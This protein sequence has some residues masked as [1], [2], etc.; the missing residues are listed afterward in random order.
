MDKGTEAATK[1]VCS[2]GAQKNVPC[3]V[4]RATPPIHFAPKDGAIFA[5]TRWALLPAPRVR[6]DDE[7]ESKSKQSEDLLEHTER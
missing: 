4:V 7:E 6:E 2:A 3:E 5:G 1:R